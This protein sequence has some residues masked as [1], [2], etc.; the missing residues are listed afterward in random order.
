[1]QAQLQATL[2]HWI[3]ACEHASPLEADQRG[4]TLW[5]P[6]SAMPTATSA[7]SKTHSAAV[8][9]SGCLLVVSEGTAEVDVLSE[10]PHDHSSSGGESD[11]GGS[12][13]TTKTV[14]PGFLCYCPPVKTKHSWLG[15]TMLAADVNEGTSSNSK[16][17]TTVADLASVYDMA[18]I[19]P[20][21]QALPRC[22]GARVAPRRTNGHSSDKSAGDNSGEKVESAKRVVVTV[23]PGKDLH[24]LLRQPGMQ[25]LRQYIGKQSTLPA[26]HWRK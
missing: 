7:L 23:V 4:A 2:H 11:G 25:P 14:G 21:L 18:K 9:W 12:T 22:V 15:Q 26:S 3:N 6:T 13:V 17:G 8:A 19:P 5:P 16:S 20:S 10:D 24:E 1:M